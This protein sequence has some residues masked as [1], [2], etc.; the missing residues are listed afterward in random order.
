MRILSSLRSFLCFCFVH[1]IPIRREEGERLAKEGGRVGRQFVCFILLDTL[2]EINSTLV[3]VNKSRS[4]CV[5]VNSWD[6]A[7]Q[8]RAVIQTLSDKLLNRASTLNT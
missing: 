7:C 6:V 4:I 2:L 1:L 3:L 8:A 5:K